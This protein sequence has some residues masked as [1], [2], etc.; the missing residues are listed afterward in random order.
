VAEA[1]QIKVLRETFN[2]LAMSQAQLPNGVADIGPPGEEVPTT[3]PSS[4]DFGPGAFGHCALENAEDFGI[5][6][7][8]DVE[9]HETSSRLRD[10][11]YIARREQDVI[12][13][14]APGDVG[15]IDGV[16]QLAP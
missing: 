6:H 11:E 9:A 2:P 15:G 14:G 16:R 12:G 13:E 10:A 8:R 5:L 3:P 4:T 7:H 1:G